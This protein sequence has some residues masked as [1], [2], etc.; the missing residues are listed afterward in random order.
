MCYGKRI[1]KRVPLLPRP[2]PQAI[3]WVK[4]VEMFLAGGCH[5]T[6]EGGGKKQNPPQ[7]TKPS[8]PF[9]FDLG[10]NL[11]PDPTC[12]GQLDPDYISKV[13]QPGTR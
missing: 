6:E 1:K 7:K 5:M 2:A 13:Y 3:C 9:Q 12:S 4:Y 8:G 11:I 10:G